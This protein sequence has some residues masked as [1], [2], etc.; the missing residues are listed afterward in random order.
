[1]YIFLYLSLFGLT[2]INYKVLCIISVNQY[3]F[4]SN[5]TIIGHFAQL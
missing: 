2:Y 4:V 1:M 5:Y 3:V